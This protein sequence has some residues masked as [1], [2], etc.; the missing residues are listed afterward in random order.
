MSSRRVLDYSG[1]K[2]APTTTGGSGTGANSVRRNA[3]V[4]NNPSSQ[5]KS[6]VPPTRNEGGG[7][8]NSS[9]RSSIAAN[10]ATYDPNRVDDDDV[11]VGKIQTNE[12]RYGGDNYDVSVFFVF[13]FSWRYPF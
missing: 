13:F 1:K 8:K 2:K 10:D 7:S 5:V 11:T 9:R 6:A 4:L 3:G 12:E